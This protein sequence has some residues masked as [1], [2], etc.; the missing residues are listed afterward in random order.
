MQNYSF[1]YFTACKNSLTSPVT[2]SLILNM[3]KLKPNLVL[4][5]QLESFF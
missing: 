2:A 4:N 3:L 5:L 1:V